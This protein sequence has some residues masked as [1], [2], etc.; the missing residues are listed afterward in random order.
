MLCLART[1]SSSECILIANLGSP[2]GPAASRNVNSTTSDCGNATDSQ[3]LGSLE[4]SEIKL[5][6]SKSISS[7]NLFG[8]GTISNADS[9]S[10]CL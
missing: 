3:N 7:I 9:L 10:I 5:N 2:T 1:I 8:V 6:A 4:L